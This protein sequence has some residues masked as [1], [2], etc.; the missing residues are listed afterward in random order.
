MEILICEIK[1]G[2]SVGDTFELAVDFV[3]VCG[4]CLTVLSIASDGLS[5]TYLGYWHVSS[6]RIEFTVVVLEYDC[7]REDGRRQSGRKLD[8]DMYVVGRSII[9]AE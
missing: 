5:G 4:Y 9:S 3:T 2:T 1:V 6:R 8:S 7:Q